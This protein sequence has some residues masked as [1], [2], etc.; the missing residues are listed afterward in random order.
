MVP[1]SFLT[2]AG[3]FANRHS[4][5]T[6]TGG[7]IRE[8]TFSDVTTAMAES[9]RGFRR[10]SLRAHARQADQ[11]RAFSRRFHEMTPSTGSA[12]EDRPSGRKVEDGSGQKVINVTLAS[13]HFHRAG[14]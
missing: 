14:A 9:S 4:D 3:E 11:Y 13:I 2:G 10:C 6:K 12:P 8:S 7:F 1:S 5:R